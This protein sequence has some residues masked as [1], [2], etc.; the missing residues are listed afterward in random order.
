MR[1]ASQDVRGRRLVAPVGLILSVAII[2]GT[3]WWLAAGLRVET[4][5]VPVPVDESGAGVIPQP[6]PQALAIIETDALTADVVEL[7]EAITNQ[8]AT[9]PGV[10]AVESV[11]NIGVLTT[12]PSGGLTSTP[13][14]GS[15]S[16]LDASVTLETRAQR[17][18]AGQLGTA[19]LLSSD[20]HTF[21][22][23]AEIDPTSSPAAQATAARSFRDRAALGHVGVGAARRRVLRR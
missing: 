7:V 12:L 17:A 21:L 14:F 1:A 15:A 6:G 22:I 4:V 11:T 13:A 16:T 3:A 23:A 5:T 19:G 2:A 8:S 10:T 20:G 18:A 9:V